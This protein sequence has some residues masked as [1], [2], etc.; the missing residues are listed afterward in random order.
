M[1]AP[2]AVNVW[3]DPASVFW[4]VTRFRQ[5]LAVVTMLMCAAPALAR[6]EEPAQGT[7][8]SRP[9]ARIAPSHRFLDNKN[10]LL[11][12][13]ETAGLITDASSTRRVLDQYPGWTIEAD[14]I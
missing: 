3:Q 6:A 11:T 2:S 5:L 4:P 9:A 14:P 1:G 8:D 7:I 10:A 13:I 12:G